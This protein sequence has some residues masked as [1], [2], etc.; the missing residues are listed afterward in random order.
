MTLIVWLSKIYIVIL[1]LRY[2]MSIQDTTFSQFGR[3]IAKITNP[4]LPKKNG[5][6]YIPLWIISLI[7]VSSLLYSIAS[8]SIEFLLNL[9]KIFN[10]YVFFFMSLY[11]VFIIFG[12]LAV[13]GQIVY[14]FYM[15]GL[16][17]VKMTRVFIPINSGKIVIPTIIV[18]Y[19]LFT[20]LSFIINTVF[21]IIIYQN[22]GNLLSLL[23]SCFALGAYNIFN[24]LYL[25]SIILIVRALISWVSPDPRNI[26]V[27]FI[28]VITEPV[29]EPL[30][31]LIPPVGFIDFSA[32]IAI[33]GFY[34]SSI[35]LKGVVSPFI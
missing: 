13:R 34:F 21:N 29:L 16:P 15:L 4:V 17:W 33:I 14:F 11:I 26:L 28:Y 25:M 5:K 7:I 22:A 6:S 18:V 8:T 19:V 32:L 9:N 10:D 31:K 24:L 27:Q 2:V 3:V 1:L 23:G 12:S 35:I 30:R 20:F